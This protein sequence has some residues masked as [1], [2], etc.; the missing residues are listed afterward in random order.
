[1]RSES[2][3][4][5]EARRRIASALAALIIAGTGVLA[6]AQAAN[7]YAFGNCKWPGPNLTVT[8][9]V[10]AGYSAPYTQSRSNW[11][12]NSDV[13]LTSGSGS[14]F[15]VAMT[16][17]TGAPGY[18]ERSCNIFGNFNYTHVY[19]NTYHMQGYS[20]PARRTVFSDEIGHALGLNHVS[21]TSAIMYPT[22]AIYFV[23][24]LYTP[25][26]DDING[27]NANY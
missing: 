15:T 14:S 26:A 18:T 22:M 7:A 3:P 11:S 21:S 1:M 16:Y 4:P 13:N 9:S 6:G 17:N 24:N 10:I 12:N 2:S 5:P 23:Y 25:Q 8:D 27:V 20:D 19:G